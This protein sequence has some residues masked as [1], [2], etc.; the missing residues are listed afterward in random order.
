MK[1]NKIALQIIAFGLIAFTFIACDEDYAT[2]E[3]DVI[4]NDIA[5]NFDI[6]S[7]KHNI[8][9]YTK[10]L[11]PIDKP[12]Q[13]NGLGLST[14]G[15]Y[16]DVYGKTTASF[17]TQLSAS[18]YDPDFGDGTIID[19]VVVT[20]PFFST[21]TG[22]DDDGNVTYEVDSILPKDDTYNS[23]KL[24]IFE[25]NY[26]IRDFD[27]FG[28][29]NESQAYYSNKT[30][31]SAAESFSAALEGEELILIPDFQTSYDNGATNNEISITDDVY[32]LEEADDEDDEDTDPQVT[33][34]IAPGIR[35]KLDP[36]FWQN[37]IIDKEGDAVL[38]NQNNFLNYFK[39]LYFKAE[40]VNNEGSFLILD[41]S[42]SNAN[43][44]I[45]YKKLTSATDD[46]D[47]ATDTSSYV[48]NFGPNR[49]NFY[50]NNFTTPI[51]SGDPTTGD[52]KIYLKG[53]EGS[54]A[55]IK[56]FNGEDLDDD[57]EINTFENFK[58]EFVVTDDKG[59]FVS[60]KRLVNE[61]N[62]VFYVDRNQLDMAN[63][64]SDNEPNRLYLYDMDNKTPLIDYFLD[65]TNTSLP[66]ISKYSHLGILERDESN[67]DKGVKYKLRITEHINNLLVRDSTNVELGLAVSLSV[68]LENSTLGLTQKKV[69]NS[70][71]FTVPIGSILTPRGTILHGNGSEDETKR[72]YL[73]IYYTKPN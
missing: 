65:A 10:A 18:S 27:P 37:K 19:S 60:S 28:D 22:F 25:N 49:I 2:L 64:V 5:T 31:S 6:L 30:G 67:D 17:V 11:N 8:I 36:T 44:T 73:E 58:N 12:V 16:D 14:L 29:V 1:K 32:V 47:D 21:S 23:I 15:L 63:E 42:S 38:S 13:T 48:L 34:R 50:D 61:A 43:I 39:G 33:E 54:I 41:A 62:L 56:L 52:S 24:R 7:E 57:P 35:V 53:G 51:N 26:F 70:N 4:N 3:S 66:S 9:T 46:A 69:Q 55:G 72:V 71:D 59:K 45:Y 20:I 68:N 40:A